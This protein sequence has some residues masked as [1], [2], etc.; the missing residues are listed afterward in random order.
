MYMRRAN[1]GTFIEHLEWQ[2]DGLKWSGTG[3][4]YTEIAWP[5]GDGCWTDAITGE[6]LL[7]G[8]SVAFAGKMHNET[9]YFAGKKRKVDE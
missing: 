4:L 1:S 8:K 5:H 3:L 6:V 2:K 9:D 7:Q